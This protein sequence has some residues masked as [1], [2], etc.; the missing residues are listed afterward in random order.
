VFEE[1]WKITD[2]KLKLQRSTSLNNM[3]LGISPGERNIR[4]TK[5]LAYARTFFA[6]IWASK[7]KARK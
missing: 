6:V 3:S 5:R 1:S 2:L 4:T 7:L